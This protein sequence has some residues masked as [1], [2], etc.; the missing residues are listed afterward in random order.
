MYIQ[1]AAAE[2]DVA[3]AKEMCEKGRTE[4]SKGF[5]A[6]SA[7]KGYFSLLYPKKTSYFVTTVTIA[8]NVFVVHTRAA[9]CTHI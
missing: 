3:Q 7:A 2:L 6:I 8:H 1:I 5:A 4:L 9:R